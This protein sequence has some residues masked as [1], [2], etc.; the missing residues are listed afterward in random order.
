M[1]WKVLLYS[2]KEDDLI[3]VHK[4]TSKEQYHILA[5]MD[6]AYD[7][8]KYAVDGGSFINFDDFVFISIEKDIQ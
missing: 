8:Q 3:L 5:D 7:I 2:P 1:S 6:I 4:D